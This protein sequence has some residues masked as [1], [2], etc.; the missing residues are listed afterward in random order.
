MP[1]H[2]SDM[3]R[4]FGGREG[5]CPVTESVSDRLLRLPF[6]YDLARTFPLCDRYFASV[7]AQTYP[8]RRFLLAATALGQVSDP[9]PGVNDPPPPNGTI[10]DLLNKRQI[11]PEDAYARCLDKNK[12]RPLLKN[13]PEEWE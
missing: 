9:F 2:L 11:S 10:M 5:D 1:L 7:M 4:R 3:G 8:N 6:Y 12:F 13:P